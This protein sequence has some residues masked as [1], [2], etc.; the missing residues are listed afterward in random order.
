MCVRVRTT[1]RRRGEETGEE[2][3]EGG[4]RGGCQFASEVT[5]EGTGWFSA[6]LPEEL[7]SP[8]GHSSVAASGR[9]WRQLLSR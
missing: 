2:T 9:T 8:L 5:G 3:G 7:A 6:R 1:V 4:E